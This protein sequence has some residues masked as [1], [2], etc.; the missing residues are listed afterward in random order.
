MKNQRDYFNAEGIYQSN[1]F[2]VWKFQKTD[3]AIKLHQM[4]RLVIW[5]WPDS[6]ISCIKRGSFG[7]IYMFWN[8]ISK[9]THPQ[10]KE[11]INFFTIKYNHIF[12]YNFLILLKVSL[13]Q[14]AFDEYFI[15]MK[16]NKS[17]SYWGVIN[18]CNPN[19]FRILSPLMFVLK[20]AYSQKVA[21]KSGCTLGSQINTTNYFQ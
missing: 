9:H 7:P 12:F 17:D 16:E 4:W 6:F 11:Q 15:Q 3:K 19:F 20:R 14:F 10:K 21:S 8:Y 1:R 18:Y 5:Q 13:I 2:V